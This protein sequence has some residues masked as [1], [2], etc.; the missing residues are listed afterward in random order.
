MYP[1][2]KKMWRYFSNNLV[3]HFCAS[4]NSMFRAERGAQQ[5]LI[6]LDNVLS[7]LIVQTFAT[8]RMCIHSEIML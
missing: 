8:S 5:L 3:H 1:R 2:N 4:F 6:F 7:F